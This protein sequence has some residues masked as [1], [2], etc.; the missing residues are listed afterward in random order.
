[1]RKTAAAKAQQRNTIADRRRRLVLLLRSG[2]SQQEAAAS[3][4]VSAA[5]VSDDL[6]VLRA[7]A[8]REALTELGPLIEQECN[9][10]D[11]DEAD[12]RARL[13]QTTE[14]RAVAALYQQI[15]A[16]QD[17]RARWRGFEHAPK[18]AGLAELDAALKD[19][20]LL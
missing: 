7:L 13:S 17:R 1:M 6:A 18:G 5:T 20:G 12:L 10:L 9:A 11:S 4:G 14:P 3:L 19:L 15:G 2:L 16:V 8:T